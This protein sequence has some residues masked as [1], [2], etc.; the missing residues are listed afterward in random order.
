MSDITFKPDFV[1]RKAFFHI[2]DIEKLTK[3]GLRQGFYHVGKVLRS[4]AS[5]AILAKDKTGIVYKVRRGKVTRRHRASSE[6]QSFANLS[7]AAR[8]SLKFAVKGTS[9]LEFGFDKSAET[10]YTKILET[11]L[12]RPALG[13]AVK[14]ESGNSISI[15]EGELRKALL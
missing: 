3:T 4:S 7:G 1:N 11:N 12:N 8:R 6:G 5:K 10:E 14:K 2:Q 15:M 13:N 9:E